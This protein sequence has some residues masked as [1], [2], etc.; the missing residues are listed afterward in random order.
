MRLISVLK[1]AT[2]LAGVPAGT[3]KPSHTATTKSATPASFMVGTSGSRGERFLAVKAS[4]FSLPA[5]I[6][7]STVG[8]LKKPIAT[9]PLITARTAAGAPR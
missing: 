2:T 5:L 7:G 6:W 9:S 1:R 3:A 4:A 8:A